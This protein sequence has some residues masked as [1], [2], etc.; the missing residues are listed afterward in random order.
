MLNRMLVHLH[1]RVTWNA[2]VVNSERNIREAKLGSSTAPGKAQG[3]RSRLLCKTP[4]SGHK[5]LC[6]NRRCCSQLAIVVFTPPARQGQSSLSGSR[7]CPNAS[8]II[9]W[10]LESEQARNLITARSYIGSKL[11]AL[12]SEARR[13]T[14]QPVSTL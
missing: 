11:L 4:L 6:I 1:T 2:A 3:G 8:T 5:D 7:F 12:S 13:Q 10:R 14:H 9:T